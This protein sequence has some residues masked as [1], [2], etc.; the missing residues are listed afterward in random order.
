MEEAFPLN[1]SMIRL[2]MMGGGSGWEALFGGMKGA[3]FWKCGDCA[4]CNLV[5]FYFWNDEPLCVCVCVHRET[6]DPG[7]LI[8]LFVAAQEA[9]WRV[10]HP[11]SGPRPES[12]NSMPSQ[13]F[14]QGPHR[15]AALPPPAPTCQIL[16][17]GPA[18]PLGPTEKKDPG[19]PKGW[20]PW[21]G[22]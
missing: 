17:P 9:M 16:Q 10:P 22:S 11:T 4:P 19:A 7:N 2:I 6:P 1:V 20:A 14:P 21:D 12:G 18:F 8:F 5:T 15:Q 13:I 3:Y